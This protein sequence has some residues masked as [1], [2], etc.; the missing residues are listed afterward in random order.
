MKKLK[1]LLAATLYGAMMLTGGCGT[2]G[3]NDHDHETEESEKEEHHHEGEEL[4][5]FSDKQAKSAGVTTMK[6]TPGEFAT[7]INVAAEVI[8]PLGDERTLAAPASGIVTFSG[9]RLTPGS[10]VQ[11]GSTLF[12]ISAERIAGAD[13][14]AT[15]RA[16]LASASAKLE[17]AKA[18]IADH[19]ISQRE[20]DDIEAEYNAARAAL[21]TP[22]AKAAAGGAG[23]ASPISGYIASCLVTP[24]QYVTAGEP[25]ATVSTNRRLQL[26]ADV[27]VRYF[28][29]ASSLTSANF[30][31]PGRSGEVVDLTSHNGRIVSYGKSSSDGSLYF[32]VIFEFDN[33]GGLISGAVVQTR[34]LGGMRQGV[35][36]VP[37]EALTEEEGAYFVYLL[38]SPGHYEKQEVTIGDSD[39]HNVEITSGLKGGE[40]IVNKGAYHLRLAANS[41]K[42]PEGHSHNH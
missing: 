34:L 41:G 40:T 6:V 38:H 27:P 20:Y 8:S 23:V 25:L 28:N 22:D 12:H 16:N 29:E 10:S 7:V 30:T 13:N 14:N 3:H 17:R 5:E 37:R 21:S 2:D 11:A 18:L 39:G 15:L 24:G 26:R 36:N 35:I 33:P 32:P 19:L 4:I 31:L 42:A 1:Y 9:S